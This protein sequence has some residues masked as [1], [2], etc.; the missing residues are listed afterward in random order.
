MPNW[1]ENDLWILGPKRVVDETVKTFFSETEG[2]IPYPDFNKIIPYPEKYR[3]EDEK[4]QR[5]NERMRGIDLSTVDHST[6]EA[7]AKLLDVPTTE[8]PKI[9][10]GWP[11]DGYNQGGYHWRIK[12]WG[13]KWPACSP[14]NFK[15]LKRG[16]RV[17]FDTPWSPPEPVL[18][19][20]SELRPNLE[21]RLR[22]YE[23]G[24]G[25]KGLRVFRGGRLTDT[26]D[27]D[28][29]GRRGG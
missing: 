25:F 23:T 10:N 2:G 9:E 12:N 11:R 20:L 1:C 22:F 15:M 17:S 3:T 6:A 13:T 4:A 5:C 29:K 18:Q 27:G 28:Y 7:W 16:L 24:M 14:H 8:I 21:I 26:M 19:K